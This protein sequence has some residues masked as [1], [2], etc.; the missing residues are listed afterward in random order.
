M[1]GA[2]RVQFRS[3][4]K[5]RF[6]IGDRVLISGTNEE[7]MITGVRYGE[8]AYDV[9]CG[10]RWFKNLLP[11]QVRLAPTRLTSSRH[12]PTLWLGA[13]RNGSALGSSER[14]ALR[15]Y[16]RYGLNSS[17]RSKAAPIWTPAASKHRLTSLCHSARARL[18]FA[19][20]PSQPRSIDFRSH[21]SLI[22]P[23]P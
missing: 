2:K 14:S 15:T 16:L 17:T 12:G 11:E 7:G 9:R 13:D 22:H 1:V 20:P 5:A 8:P 18:R 10:S 3:V 23:Q 19:G 6:E 21:A 4:T